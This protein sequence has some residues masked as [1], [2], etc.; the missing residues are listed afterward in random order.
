MT[1][2]DKDTP[3]SALKLNSPL[4]RGLNKTVRKNLFPE[5]YP[6]KAQQAAKDAQERSILEGPEKAPALPS[7][8]DPNIREQLLEEMRRR[9]KGT[10]VS[11][12]ILTGGLA[13]S[14][15][16]KTVLG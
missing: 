14:S 10:G 13:Q 3:S 2:M 15:F 7:E 12:T 16:G 4:A 6:S 8:T 1:F 9:Q 5:N 11:S